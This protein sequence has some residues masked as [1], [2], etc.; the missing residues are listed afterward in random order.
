LSSLNLFIRQGEISDKKLMKK[1]TKVI[2]MS[3]EINKNYS[4]IEK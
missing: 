4:D 1:D 2:K 3:D